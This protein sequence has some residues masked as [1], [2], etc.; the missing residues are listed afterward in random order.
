[1]ALEDFIP[2]YPDLDDPDIQTYI[3]GRKEFNELA[4]ALREPA[5]KRGQYYLHQ[6]FFIRLMAMADRICNF[7][8]TGTGKSCAFI[9]AAE[10]LKT[11][12]DYRRVYLLER[13]PTTINEM[14]NQIVC[15]CTDGVYETEKVKQATEAR[16]RKGNMTRALKEWYTIETYGKFADRARRMSDEQIIDEF[17]GCIFIIDEAHNIVND[18][19]T[20]RSEEAEGI[21]HQL[22][23]VLH[24]ILRSKAVAV[25]AT[26]M[27]NEVNECVPILN[28]MLPLDRQ[29]PYDW[30]YRYVSL[31]QMEPFC[32]GLI[33]FVRALDS[34]VTPEFIGER[35]NTVHQIDVLPPDWQGD[36]ILPL[37]PQVPP[38]LPL[39]KRF[40]QSQT[41][42]NGIPMG[43]LQLEAYVQIIAREGLGGANDAFHHNSIQ[44]SCFVFP[45]GSVGGVFDHDAT[46]LATGGIAKYIYSPRPDVYEFRDP[47][48]FMDWE[49]RGEHTTFREWIYN[50]GD[51]DNLRRL[52]CKFATILDIELTQPGCSFVYSELLNGSTA[53]MLAMCFEAFGFERYNDPHS[54]FVSGGG[55]SVCTP[56]TRIMLSGVTK[57]LRYALL[58]SD[59]TSAKQDSSLELFNS[60][61]NA[62][63]A[64]I[65]TMIGSRVSR[66]GINLFHCLRYHQLIPGW[67]PAG[68]VQSMNRILRAVSHEDLIQQA[69][70][71]IMHQNN[72]TIEAATLLV[73]IRVH[74]YRHAA[75]V[76]PELQRDVGSIDLLIYNNAEI[77]DFD[78]RRMMRIFKQCAIDCQINYARNVR[79]TDIDGSV[80]CD[81]DECA[82]QCV[83]A[84]EP[85]RELDFSTYD[86]LY[87][88]ETVEACI[89]ELVRLL[90]D[91]GS[92]TFPE[93]ITMYVVTGRF[94]ERYIYMAV[95]RIMERRLKVL[96]RFGYNCYINTDGFMLYT[97]RD[98]PIEAMVDPLTTFQDLSVYAQEMVMVLPTTFTD[99]VKELLTA[100][101]D[102][103]ITKINE[104]AE[105]DEMGTRRL[106]KLLNDLTFDTRVSLIE[107]ALIQI[108][109][110]PEGETPPLVAKAIYD[111][112]IAYIVRTQEPLADLAQVAQSLQNRGQSKK[113]KEV[114]EI[115]DPGTG[116]VVYLHTFRNADYDLTAYAVTAKFN[117]GEN[118][119]IFKPSEGLGWRDALPYEAPVYAYIIREIM[120]VMLAPFEQYGVYGTIIA[121]AIFR[122][123]DSRTERKS[124]LRTDR[125]FINDGR[126]CTV[127][128]TRALIKLLV[129][130]NVPAERVDAT[131]HGIDREQTIDYIMARHH[132]RHRAE[133]D[134]MTD[135][136][137]IHT[138]QWYASGVG[139]TYMCQALQD[140]FAATDRLLVV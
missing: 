18:G 6:R 24:L 11:T 77:K 111:R 69:A 102:A 129:E 79:P 74:I 20:S 127:W 40:F 110:T 76:P 5:P 45:D 58:S 19:A 56:E 21:Y 70:Q 131:L 26:P 140:F 97:Q 139:K 83:T 80:Q 106:A 37:H 50:G 115:K 119:R 1:M 23:R 138:Y 93:L 114:K 51:T 88:E 134:A 41:I 124:L 99:Q 137:L 116:E 3:T 29:L 120:D 59:V 16:F 130:L 7:Q 32:R 136:Q 54:P 17:S 75:V 84:T 78:I 105:F 22:H 82:Y 15:K 85:A 73:D 103:I 55:G 10:F 101:Q 94:R 42:I 2:V 86:I 36:P 121:D 89:I 14:R 49:H 12:G 34:G 13:G 25:T 9:G 117:K 62:N 107:Q 52:S 61:E 96:N 126:M 72:V 90:Q 65:K 118:I 53:V 27:I 81:Y 112:Y 38:P 60:T 132:T 95:A 91:R 31:H 66:D 98:F 44:A 87:A 135:A 28:L 108:A 123:R 47:P 104:I 4:A 133:L 33:T 57:K 100:Q 109:Q 48:D 8:E 92:V 64:Y 128:N 39:V 30:D 43:D 46:H 113:T 122:I 125:R 67:H 63:S 68:M 35:I 71:A